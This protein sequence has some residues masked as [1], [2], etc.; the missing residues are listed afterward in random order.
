MS[1]FSS[2]DPF[3]IIDGHAPVVVGAPHHGTHPGMDADLATGP[4]ALALAAKLNARTVV[5]S[6]LRRTVDVNKNPL[7]LG[8]AVRHYAIRYQNEL[9]QAQPRLVIELHGHT[10]G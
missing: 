8:K 3:Q 2:P 6:N 4:I 5:V 1:L 9:F 7:R 10:S